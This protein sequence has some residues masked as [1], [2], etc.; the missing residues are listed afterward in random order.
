MAL[1]GSGIGATLLAASLFGDGSEVLEL[2][3]SP[4]KLRRVREETFKGLL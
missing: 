3:R 2:P 4:F 1:V